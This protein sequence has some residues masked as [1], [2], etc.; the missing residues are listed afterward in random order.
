MAAY[1]I[2]LERTSTRAAPWYVIPGDNKEYARMVVKHL[3]VEQLRE[4]QQPWPRPVDDL[5]T[6]RKHLDAT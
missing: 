4:L 6:A 5:E 3:L 2:A 1:Q